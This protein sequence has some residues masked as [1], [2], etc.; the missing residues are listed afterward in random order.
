MQLCL[1]LPL[2]KSQAGYFQVWGRRS[3]A[4]PEPAL[5]TRRLQPCTWLHQP[6]VCLPTHPKPR[7]CSVS[8]GQSSQSPAAFIILLKGLHFRAFHGHSPVFR[9][10]SQLAL[11]LEAMQFSFLAPPLK[12]SGGGGGVVGRKSEALCSCFHKE[13]S[14]FNLFI[15]CPSLY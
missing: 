8:R 7:L 15:I 14:G 2:C 11:D 3:A 1:S 13:N 10:L 6:P 9:F 5:R 12:L 4:P